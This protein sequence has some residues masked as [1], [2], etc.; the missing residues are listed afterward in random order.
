MD[1]TL[2][3]TPQSR[4]HHWNTIPILIVHLGTLSLNFTSRLFW[5]GGI[6]KNQ[7]DLNR[8]ILYRET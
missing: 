5:F 2:G 6:P 3:E 4:K 8:L 7:S 1:Q